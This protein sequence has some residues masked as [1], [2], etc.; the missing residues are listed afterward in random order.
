MKD[1]CVLG[2]GI[3]GSNIANLLKKDYT[4]EI[5]DKAKGLGGRC[6]NRRYKNRLSF[7]HGLQYISPK[8]KK[9]SSFLKSLV[10]KKVFKEWKGTHLN[11][12]DTSKETKKFI[13]VKGNNDISK[14]LVKN[15]KV[16]SQSKITKIIF[17]SNH[18]IVI[19]NNKKHF[20]KNL[21]LTCPYPQIKPLAKKYLGKNFFNLNV[22]MQPNI[23]VL[24]AFKGYQNTPISSIKFKD[25]IL[26]WCA[27]ENSK[28]RF[29][30]NLNLWT[31][32]SNVKWAKKYI[33]KCKDKKI[34][35]INKLLDRFCF[36]TGFDKKNVVFKNIHGWKYSFNT[37]STSKKSYWNEK[38]RL[39][40]C[41]DWFVGPYAENAWLSSVS[42]FSEIKKNPP[43][44]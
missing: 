44:V 19:A 7:D 40:I 23:T 42:L 38:Y 31:I 20:F 5:F 9:F 41:A 30:S 1:F 8:N 37:H 35:V 21:I 34:T 29:N 24:I 10:H 39:G 27:N 32:Q 43:R 15:V 33:N 22:N 12:K 25:D 16:N 17:N 14:Y 36:L 2:S 28:K 26:G 4:V 11:L 13:G 6:S 18:W 3:S